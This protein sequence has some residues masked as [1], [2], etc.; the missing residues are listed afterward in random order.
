M[1]VLLI[2]TW[3]DCMCIYVTRIVHMCDMT[4]YS[5]RM[6]EDANDCYAVDIRD[7]I[8]LTHD[9]IL[10]IYVTWL[11]TCILDMAH[12]YIYTW[13]GSL[14]CIYVTWLTHMYI[15]DMAHS[16]VWYDLVPKQNGRG[17]RRCACWRI[18]VGRTPP[19]CKCA[20]PAK[21]PYTSESVHRPHMSAKEPYMS[22][23]DVRADASS[24]A[25]PPNCK[26]AHPQRSPAYLQKSPT[27]QNLYMGPV[28]LQKSPV[29][30]QK[31]CVLTHLCAAN[32]AA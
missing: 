16:Y 12:P 26:C 23:E 10:L 25:T 31:M 4:W 2:V 15:R 1:T 20:H 19:H 14:I 21:E 5:S 28:C 7:M 17:C 24:G 30:P 11:H 27:Y 32:P 13:H 6:V 29:C 22:A 8:L 9:M 18:L 3:Y